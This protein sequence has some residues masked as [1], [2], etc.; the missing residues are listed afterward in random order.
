MAQEQWD[1]VTSIRIAAPVEA[2]FAFMSDARN[3]SEWA[4][5]ALHPVEAKP[6]AYIGNS[7]I[8]GQRVF[9]QVAAEPMLKHV[10]FRTG[11]G[12]DRLEQLILCRIVDDRAED[13]RDA[14]ILSLA[15][16]RLPSLPAQRWQQLCASHELEM[17][18]IKNRIEAAR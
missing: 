1:H 6:D 11:S 8:D 17:F 7:M 9:V 10:E 14:C 13:G 12:W 4:L 2:A 18:I 3:I 16:Q 5:G 15:T